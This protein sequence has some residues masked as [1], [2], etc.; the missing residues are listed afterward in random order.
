MIVAD[1]GAIYALIDTRERNYEILRRLFESNPKAWVLPWAIL[2]EVD[3]LI[4][5]YLG[6]KSQERFLSDLAEGLLSVA[7]GDERDLVAAHRINA[8]Y[9]SLGLGF[10]DS[11]VLAVA[12]RLEAEAIAT[13]DLRHF[14]AVK[15][16]GDPKLLP[17][18]L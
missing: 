3:Y 4:A 7:W 10:V 13:L 11:V 2:P 9:A 14:G 17:R 8:R 1:T 12:E 18:D 6:V 15:I 5:K 16:K